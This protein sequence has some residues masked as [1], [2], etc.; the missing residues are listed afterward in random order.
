VEVKERFEKFVAVPETLPA[1]LRPAVLKIAGRYSDNHL[2]EQMLT[3]ARHA[4]GTEERELYYNA[5]C[6]ALDPDLA[7]A[8]LAISLSNELSPEEASGV[9]L[10]VAGNGEHTELAWTF[11]KQ[12]LRELLAKVEVFSRTSYVPAIFSSFSDTAHADELEKQAK[13]FSEDAQAKAD[14]TAMEI[15]FKAAFKKRELPIIDHWITKQTTIQN[16]N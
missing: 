15:R 1:Y 16:E 11:A 2:Y 8:T 7:R 4:N 13:N 12:H 14:E 3:L 9:V 6:S 5:L 10:E